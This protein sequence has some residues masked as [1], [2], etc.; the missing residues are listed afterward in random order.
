MSRPWM[1]LYVADYLGDTQH[2]STIEHGA[3]LLLIFQYWQKEGLPNDETQLMRIARMSPEEWSNAVATLQALFQPGWKHPRIDAELQETDEKYEKRAKAGK[4]GGKA[5]ALARREAKQAK[6][7]AERQQKLTNAS[8]NASSNAAAKLNH[9]HPHKEDSVPSERTPMASL[10]PEKEL[11]DRG[12]QVLGKSAGGLIVKLLRAKGG[13]IA[14]TRAAIEQASTKQN[15]GEYI[16]AAIK[17]GAGP[18]AFAERETNGYV[19]ILKERLGQQHEP[20]SNI[21][22]VT[23]NQ[24]AGPGSA[25]GRPQLARG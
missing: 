4:A 7:E 1:P 22:D 3:Y 11:F 6:L 12:K 15:P 8:S 13:N 5:S 17:G 18:P 20:D 2:L 25:D 21:I 10:D 23:P 16:A 24:H 9:P 14:L 19:T